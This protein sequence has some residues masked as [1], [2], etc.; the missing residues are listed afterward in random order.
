V[1]KGHK[2]SLLNHPL[3]TPESILA[4]RSITDLPFIDYDVS[5][6]RD[7]WERHFYQYA[8]SLR[9]LVSRFPRWPVPR[10]TVTDEALKSVNAEL[11]RSFV[12]LAREHGSTPIVVYFP[13]TSDF[14]SDSTSR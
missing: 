11:V 8:Y 1:M 13:S 3:P 14:V 4:T 7:E 9:F 12:R 6:E 2:L 5:F 10:S